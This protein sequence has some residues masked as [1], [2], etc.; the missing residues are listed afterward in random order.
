MPADFRALGRS[1][2][3]D[4]AFTRSHRAPVIIFKHSNTCPV[5]AG[6]YREVS[7]LD[8][9]VEL[10]TVQLARDVSREVESRTGVRHES[11]QVLLLRNGTA[12]W[13][14]SHWN[15]TSQA[16]AQAMSELAR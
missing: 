11:P 16:V 7:K 10:L 8:V 4:K 5:S 12:V 2:D 13:S 9:E 6:A 15:V 14:A 3:L 1:E